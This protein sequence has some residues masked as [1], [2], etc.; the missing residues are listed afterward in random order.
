MCIAAAKEEDPRHP[1]AAST[2]SFLSLA[3]PAPLP[4]FRDHPRT[5][6][7]SSV[8]GSGPLVFVRGAPSG[9]VWML[10]EGTRVGAESLSLDSTR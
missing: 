8:P 1:M 6:P 10:S 3:I 5:A 2:I 9:D 7:I 4:S